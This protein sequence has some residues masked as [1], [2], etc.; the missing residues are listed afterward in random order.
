MEIVYVSLTSLFRCGELNNIIAFIL[1]KFHVQMRITR[2][3]LY[4]KHT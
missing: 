1:R 3:I 4:S 2:Y